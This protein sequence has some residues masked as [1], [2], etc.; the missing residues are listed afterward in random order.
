M[1]HDVSEV[2]ID[3]IRGLTKLHL[4]FTVIS[5]GVKAVYCTSPLIQLDSLSGVQCEK[6]HLLL[7]TVT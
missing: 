1:K 3:A 5:V 4:I 2:W 6:I 7:S